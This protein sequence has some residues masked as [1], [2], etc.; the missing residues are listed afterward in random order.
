MEENEIL[1]KRYE[2]AVNTY[3]KYFD[4]AIRLNLFFYGITGAIVSYYFSKNANGN[5]IE[6]A[7]ILPIVFGIGFVALCLFANSALGVSKKEI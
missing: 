4:V 5:M 1:W 2:L 3:L 7:L 6:H